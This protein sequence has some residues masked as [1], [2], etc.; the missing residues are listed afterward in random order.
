[1]HGQ[2]FGSVAFTFCTSP[3][4]HA[5]HHPLPAGSGRFSLA[6]QVLRPAAVRT[7]P[8]ALLQ[9]QIAAVP[10]AAGKRVGHG[11]VSLHYRVVVED[12]I[13]AEQRQLEA[14]L[15]AG[16]PMAAAGIAAVPGQ[17]RHNIVDEVQRLLLV[18]ILDLDANLLFLPR[19]LDGDDGRALADGPDITLFGDAHDPRRFR[20]IRRG[21]GDIA[22]AL[23][24][25]GDDELPALL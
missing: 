5:L 3:D 24:A 4:R 16:P 23:V 19:G 20:A 9:Q 14:V 25:Q 13:E 6:G 11:L 15:P 10:A 21:A 1:M 2:L 12:R 18:A 7:R 8:E 22:R 17:K